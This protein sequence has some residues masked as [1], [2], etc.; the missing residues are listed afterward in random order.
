MTLGL[1]QAQQSPLHRC[2]IVIK[3]VALV[4]FTL[5]LVP[6]KLSSLLFLLILSLFFFKVAR[7]SLSFS[8]TRTTRSAL[9]IVLLL[10]ASNT[11]F[12]GWY[13]GLLHALRFAIVF[14]LS[15]LLTMTSNPTTMSAELYVVLRYIPFFPARQFTVI[16]ALVF[17][18]IPLLL[19]EIAELEEATQ[20]RGAVKMFSPLRFAKAQMIPLL[21]G[22]LQK[23]DELSES[24]DARLFNE[25]ATPPETQTGQFLYVAI[26]ACCIAVAFLLRKLL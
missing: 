7:L 22:I 5:S 14:M 3:V 9:I 15:L 1:Y 8:F 21:A 23:C 6:P 18:L 2:H 26:L 16:I 19:R 25:E 10:F 12:L 4:A 20:S 24:M 17:N 11:Y 13:T